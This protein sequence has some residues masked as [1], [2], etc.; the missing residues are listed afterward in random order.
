MSNDEIVR[1]RARNF[2]V[3]GA[4]VI[5]YLL[6]GADL[7]QLSVLGLRVPADYPGVF[8]AAAV[9]A[10]V[11]FWWRYTTAW[12]DHGARSQFRSDY[13]STLYKKDAFHRYIVDRIDLPTLVQ[14]AQ[15]KDIDFPDEPVL[16]KVL[17][18][19]YRQ[20]LVTIR[21]LEFL[22]GPIGGSVYSIDTDMFPGS[23]PIQVKIPFWMHYRLGVPHYWK[24]A[25]RH[26]AFSIYILPHISF[27]VAIALVVC[28]LWFKDPAG[29]FGWFE[30]HES[31]SRAGIEHTTH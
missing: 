14:C 21:R 11:W 9:M 13:F 31:A 6:A 25:V 29:F 24:R 5:I 1:R 19:E 7:D 26:E 2:Y 12:L 27:A 10:M 20:L 3:F 22:P 4:A 18:G 28:K 30:L 15:D 17:Y 8:G 16:H 23:V